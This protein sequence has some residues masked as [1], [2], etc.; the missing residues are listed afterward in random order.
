MH[1][2]R[3]VDEPAPLRDLVEELRDQ[4]WYAMD[5]EFHRE[6][7][8][9]PKLA[10]VQVAWAAP[11][12]RPPPNIAFIDPLRVELR[13]L[14]AVLDGDG[15]AV[16]HAAE[17]DLEVL[18]QACGTVPSRLFDTQVAAGFLGFASASL[19]ALAA[20]LLDV[21]LPKGD[22]LTDWTRRPLDDGQRDYAAADVAHLLEL[23]ARMATDL[24]AMGRLAWAEEECEIVRR[25]RRGPQEPDTAWWRVREVR[26]VRGQARAVAQCL[27]AWREQKAAAVDRP[28]RMVLS[29]MAV[30]T[31]ASHPPRSVDDLRGLRGVDGRALGGGTSREILAAVADGLALG[32]DLLRLP[33]PEELDRR[34]RPA[35]ALASAW[36]G[37]LAVDLHIDA[38]LL[39]TRADLH[40]LLCGD[41]DARLASGWRAELVGEPVRRLVGGEAAL[42]FNGRGSLVLEPRVAGAGGSYIGGSAPG[43]DEP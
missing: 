12:S 5:T 20:Q 27:A 31:I 2:A 11:G 32:P 36:I 29:D 19:A 24:E 16:V 37:Q 30:V 6:R 14:A 28:P 33:T 25:R 35:V 1:E 8:Y 34:L 23:Q 9:W 10:L 17:Q 21:R 40:A 13:P 26:H 38:A 15:T 43:S 39:A 4:P 18:E 7:T 22:R 42:A 41:P 3:W